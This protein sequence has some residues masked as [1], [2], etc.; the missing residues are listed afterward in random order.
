MLTLTRNRR[1]GLSVAQLFLQQF[2][3]QFTVSIEL[4]KH[5]YAAGI[6]LFRFS[7]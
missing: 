6:E 5:P 2:L 7:R 1:E 3:G 4:L